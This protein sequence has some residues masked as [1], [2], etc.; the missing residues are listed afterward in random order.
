MKVLVMH[1]SKRKNGN[2]GLLASEFIRGAEEAGHQ[3]ER[4]ELGDI[5]KESSAMQEA[6]EMGKNL[7]KN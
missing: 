6:Y 7:G 3:V 2:T 4:V 5:V 1:G